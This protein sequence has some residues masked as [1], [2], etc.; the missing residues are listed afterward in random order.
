MSGKKKAHNKKESQ[1]KKHAHKKKGSQ[2]KQVRKKK[3][4]TKKTNKQ[5]I[6]ITRFKN[7]T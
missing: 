1:A 3:S 2:N 6:G 7:I 5:E 4:E